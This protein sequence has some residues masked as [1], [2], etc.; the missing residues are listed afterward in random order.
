MEVLHTPVDSYSNFNDDDYDRKIN[1]RPP[2]TVPHSEASAAIDP[3]AQEELLSQKKFY[4]SLD[5]ESLPSEVVS[6]DLVAADNNAENNDDENNMFTR[7][8]ECPVC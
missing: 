6:P 5:N 7:R 1:T 4:D 8:V 2:K 3:R